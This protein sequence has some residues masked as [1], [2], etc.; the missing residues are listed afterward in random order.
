MKK[1]SLIGLLFFVV[2]SA[3]AD[4]ILNVPQIII[5]PNGDT[6]H[7]LASGD[8][9]YNYL[10]DEDGFTIV[11]GADGYYCYATERRG[12]I[13][14]SR[15]KVGRTNPTKSRLKPHLKI[16]RKDYLAKRE[17]MFP[18]NNAKSAKRAN[19]KGTIDGVTI[20]IRFNGD[21]EFTR[22]RMTQMQNNF[23]ASTN[24]VRDYFQKVSYNQLD[25]RTTHIPANT[26]VTITSFVAANQRNHYRPHHETT[27]PSGYKDDNERARREWQLLRDA[28][29]WVRNNNLLPPGLVLDS[30]GDGYADLINFV[31]QGSSE[32]WGD[33]LWA[34]QWSLRT[35][36]GTNFETNITDRVRVR[37]YTFLPEDQTSVRTLSH[38]VYHVLGAPDLYHY[39][40]LHNS[41]A[42]VGRWDLMESG[43]G[44]MLA[45]MKM[46]Y[47]GWMSTN[48]PNLT[49]AGTYTLLSQAKNS[50]SN[51]FRINGNS[52]EYFLLEYRQRTD[53]VYEQNL[54][55]SG[56]IATRINS[57]MSGNAQYNAKDTLD[58]IY[59]LRPGGSVTSN[60]SINSANLSGKVGGQSALSKNHETKP[61]FSNG[62]LADFLIYDIVDF[63]DSIQFSFLPKAVPNPTNFDGKWRDETIILSWIPDAAQKNVVLIC[64]TLPIF[65]PPENDST[66]AIGGK[67]P[68]GATV[69]YVGN[70]SM[71]VHTPV[72]PEKTYYYK[73]FTNASLAYSLGVEFNISTTW[74]SASRFETI[75]N[76]LPADAGFYLWSSGGT[77]F[78]AGHNTWGYTKFVEFYKNNDTRRVEGLNFSVGKLVQQ[79]KDANILLSVWDV[80]NNGLPNRELSTK[81][82]PYNALRTGWNTHYFDNPPLISSDFFI[83]L[84]INYRT[85]LD[86]LSFLATNTDQSRPITSYVFWN[87]SYVSIVSRHAGPGAEPLN[88]AYAYRPVLSSGGF[89]LTSLPQRL[90]VPTQGASNL[91]ISILS[92]HADYEIVSDND[93]FFLSIDKLS[94]RI[95]V[96]V[97]PSET[98]RSGEILIIAE[99]DTARVF[100]Y[101]SPTVSIQKDEELAIVLFPNPSKDGIFYLQSD[102]GEM[103]LEV[104]DLMGRTIYSRRTF[105]NGE[106]IDLSTQKSGMY[107]LRIIKNGQQ[108]T[109]RLI[110][111]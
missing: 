111:Q 58:E 64:D 50:T 27:N 31:V 54:P 9:F 6:I 21:P 65:Y 1:I 53:D 79:N 30:D 98:D 107:F 40:D 26:G 23:G 76:F 8:E 105:S 93:W 24:S 52:T 73:L 108:K 102:G 63:G 11:Q 61:F 74:D 15:H 75:D 80:N 103:R 84:T 86:T 16:S 55:G 19:T 37:A 5:Q 43:S 2:W 67:L 33:I 77:N 83:G 18:Q 104:F 101:Q 32:G 97:D 35:V 99:T 7:C 25:I 36:G 71:F 42:P 60:G 34:H 88:I 72:E 39:K 47:G 20:Y 110:K 59:V 89:F 100:V 29:N 87:N 14:A 4:L 62:T 17:F 28:I 91:I 68:S 92:S 82:I 46:K 95:F 81:I 109:F 70:D 48:T 90:N 22:P 96:D 44:H 106:K 41:I 49:Q 66:Y 10:H 38:E 85:P 3:K 13:V 56:L 57:L 78:V 69:L 51:V 94:D 12:K 45:Y